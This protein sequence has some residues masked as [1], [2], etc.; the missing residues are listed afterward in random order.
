MKAV[1]WL[2]AMLGV[3]VVLA[4][5]GLILLL[6]TPI[7][8]G[9]QI[10]FFRRFYEVGGWQGFGVAELYARHN[11]HRLVVP[12]L[13]FLADLAWF[14]G[15]QILTIGAI[16]VSATL[17][18]VI[19]AL[20]FRGLGHRGP[21]VAV[22]L[23]V[24]LGA[25]LSPAQWENLI[26]GFQVQF[27]QVWLFATLAFALVAW[28]PAAKRYATIC[29]A[30][31]LLALLAGLASTYSMA[32]GL[33]VWPLLLLLAWWRRLPGWAVAA[34]AVLGGAVVAV[35]VIGFTV[36]T[37]HGDPSDTISQPAG[38]L[39]YAARYLTSGVSA[40]GTSG[41]EILGGL[42]MAYALVMGLCALV[43]RDRFRP[44]HAA[45]L[46]VA[47]FIIGA[48][49]MTALGRLPFGLGQANSS[50]YATPSLV[51]LLA[52]SALL[53]HQLLAF[54][55]RRWVATAAAFGALLLL[56]PGLVDGVKPV[57]R[58]IDQRD[59]RRHTIAAFLAGGYRP[60]TLKAIYPLWPRN[61]HYVLKN[62]SREGKGPFAVLDD[63]R[64]SVDHGGSVPLPG[65]ACP[66]QV[67]EARED[68]VDGLVAMG[69]VAAGVGARP[70]WVLATDR[71]D[72]VVAWGMAVVARGAGGP[73]D[74]GWKFEALGPWAGRSVGP[75]NVIAAL[76]DGTRCRIVTDVPPAP[77]RFVATVE[78]I[79]GPAVR[80][81]WRVVEG[82]ADPAGV[83]TTPPRA[84]DALAI[85]TF[86]QADTHLM[87]E[88]MI[89]PPPSPAILALPIRTGDY[90]LGVRV[91]LTEADGGVVIDSHV[92]GRPSAPGWN[93]L[94]LRGPTGWRGG[95]TDLRLR[96]SSPGPQPW[97]AI[98]VGRPVWI[99]VDQDG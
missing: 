29:G 95:D 40:I 46:A 33:L 71:R 88:V 87:A 99:P 51:F 25:M 53:L 81:P 10:D 4:G 41:Q 30:A 8:F 57:F 9:D 61:A 32:N 93:W 55:R 79:I 28:A 34:V 35:E 26:W 7:P 36:H 90:P 97:R 76:A 86:G 94:L 52:V 27:I 65:K 74:A 49:L 60:H 68:P 75:L 19:L 42:L 85:G 64:P 59:A 16:L 39:R 12:R 45:L 80:E 82:Q 23:L 31:I 77:P 47:G 89:A 5:I 37:G 62:L 20:L 66:G 84:D 96:V 6:Y 78:T 1:G 44:A 15:R 2:A 17:H 43:W 11:E 3:V 72:E 38:L 70:D 18:A 21:V 48:A 56:V 14:D 63:Y 24:A 13:W 67:V 73:D 83:G 58:L 22:F 92:F 54:D 50:R 69:W 98:A 91:D